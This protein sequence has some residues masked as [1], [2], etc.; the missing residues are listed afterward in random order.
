MLDSRVTS[1]LVIL[2]N[3]TINRSVHYSSLIE[4]YLM[5][6]SNIYK[7]YRFTS[8]IIQYTYGSAIDSISATL[9]FRFTQ[10]T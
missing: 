2:L 7:R 8:A 9:I 3:I 4:C 6:K 10:T 5:N 1:V